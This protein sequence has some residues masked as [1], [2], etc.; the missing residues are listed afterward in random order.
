MAEALAIDPSWH[1]LTKGCPPRWASE[2][3]EDPYGVFVAFT[4]ESI[5]QRL[6][7]IP[8]GAFR[9]G[10][11][12]DEPGRWDHEGPQHTVYISHGLALRHP[13]HPALWEAVMGEN[14]SRFR[15]PERPVEQVSWSGVQGFLARINERIPGLELQLPTEAQWE[16]ACRAGTETALYSGP[17]EILGANNAPALDPIAWYGGNSGVDFD[18]GEGRD[19]S[20]WEE[21]QY[22]GSKSGTHPVGKKRPNPWG[23]YDMIGNVWEW[24]AD[25]LRAYDDQWQVDPVGPLEPGADRVIRGGSWDDGARY[26]RCAYRDGYAPDV[27]DDGLGFRC[28]PSQV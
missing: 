12:E 23:L 13:L 20:G 15:S 4:L 16:H 6:R 26:C 9:M 8:A 18:L 17:I 27:R 21:K 11:P 19:S 24:C 5:T 3:G 25:G 28:A 2:W 10:S 14:P 22:P 7:W 1:P